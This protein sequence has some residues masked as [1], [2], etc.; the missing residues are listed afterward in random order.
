MATNQWRV[1]VAVNDWQALAIPYFT[2]VC[3]SVLDGYMTRNEFGRSTVTDLGMLVYHREDIF[4]YFHYYIEENPNFSLMVNIGFNRFDA[5]LASIEAESIG[6][7][8][9][10]PEDEEA[11]EYPQWLF[12]NES[13]LEHSVVRVRDDVMDIYAK[14]LWNNPPELSKKIKRFRTECA[15]TQTKEAVEIKRKEAETAFRY[16]KYEK[17]ARLY[18]EIDPS[19]LSAV[20][21]K[22]LELAKSGKINRSK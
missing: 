21:R 8:V 1:L 20:E 17:A 4:L 7:W 6:L 15:K 18:S 13:E 3:R 12:R 22:R 14:P 16:G 2:P 5:V 11:A 10:I 9:V 19:T